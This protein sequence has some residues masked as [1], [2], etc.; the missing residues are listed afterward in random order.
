M[1]AIDVGANFGYYT[2]LLGALVGE[3][4]HV[5]AIEPAPETA[6]MLRRSVALNGFEGFTTVIEAAAGAGEASEALL[7]VPER[8]PK[9]A[10]IVASPDGL[11]HIPRHVAPGRAIADR[12]ARRRPA[13]HR[14][15]SRSTPRAPRRPSS[16]ARSRRLRRDRPLL[17]LEFNAA[18]ARDPAALLAMLGAIY[19]APRYLDLHGN[20]RETTPERL[21]RESFAT[22]WLVVFGAG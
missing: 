1:T 14:L 13:P 22:D 8:E 5:L 16:P 18:R 12:R 11:D 21:L 17:V 15:S 7:F 19:G 9:N 20:V 6:A 2:I 4:G 3:A 10:Q